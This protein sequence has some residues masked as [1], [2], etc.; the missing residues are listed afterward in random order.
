MI[1]MVLEILE[2]RGLRGQVMVKCQCDC[3]NIKIIAKGDLIRKTGRKTKGCGCLIPATA[4]QKIQVN[5]LVPLIDGTNISN[6]DNKLSRRNT[7]G[8][9]GVYWHKGVWVARIQ[10]KGQEIFLGCSADKNKAAEYRKEGEL[11]YFKPFLD[12]LKEK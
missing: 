1:L 12:S 2:E 4:K 11:K 9:K 3:G 7:S 10:F 8:I 5:R 6:L